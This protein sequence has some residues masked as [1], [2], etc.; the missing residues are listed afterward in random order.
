MPRVYSDNILWNVGQF[1]ETAGGTPREALIF[2]QMHQVCIKVSR[3]RFE[4]ECKVDAPNVR[5]NEM[6]DAKVLDL[7]EIE[8]CH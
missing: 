8:I 3:F 5:R 7:I 1:R 6:R 2:F 4:F